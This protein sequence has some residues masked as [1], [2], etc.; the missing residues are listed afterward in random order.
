MGGSHWGLDEVGGLAGAGE[1][2]WAWEVPAHGVMAHVGVFTENCL[3]SGRWGE[4]W[5][6]RYRTHA[7]REAGLALPGL[8]LDQKPLCIRQ[9]GRL[10][11]ARGPAGG[12]LWEAPQGQGWQQGLH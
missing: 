2:A 3:R 5:V 11:E 4:R 1:G 7:H 10:W 6:G 9:E 8:G 12:P